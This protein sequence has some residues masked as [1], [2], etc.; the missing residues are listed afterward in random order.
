MSFFCGGRLLADISRI[1]DFIKSRSQKQTNKQTKQTNRPVQGHFV[2]IVIVILFVILVVV[3][4][5]GGLFFILRIRKDFVVG[6]IRGI[7]RF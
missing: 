1:A 5:G 7:N 3:V 4:A 2:V 6:Y